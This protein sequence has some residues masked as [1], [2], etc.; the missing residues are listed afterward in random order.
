MIV[1]S[2]ILLTPLVSDALRYPE[3]VLPHFLYLGLAINRKILLLFNGE[4]MY[5]V[6]PNLMLE[7]FIAFWLLW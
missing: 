1:S 6:D 5:L 4:C 2:F 3:F 7:V